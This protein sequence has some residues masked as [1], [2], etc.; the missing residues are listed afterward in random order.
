M[1]YP[2]LVI[3]ESDRLTAAALGPLAEA[4]RWALREPRRLSSCLRLLQRL[5]PSVLVIK[6]GADLGR[7]MALLQRAREVAPDAPVVVIVG[8]TEP[9]GGGLAW[10]LGASYVLLPPQP[11]SLLPAVVAQL[12]ERAIERRRG[13]GWPRPGAAPTPGEPE[14][15]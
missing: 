10:H 14:K 9:G 5:H 3:Y 12:M 8:G 4:R 7:E 15:P 2:Q 1:L 13:A 11:R 6:T